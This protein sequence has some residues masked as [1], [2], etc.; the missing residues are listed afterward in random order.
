[1]PFREHDQRCIRKPDLEVAISGDHLGRASDI[2]GFE[3]LEPVRTR[4]DLVAQGGGCGS[5]HALR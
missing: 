4:R 5:G 2:G 1:M 3:R